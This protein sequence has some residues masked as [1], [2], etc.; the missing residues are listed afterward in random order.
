MQ[1]AAN[2]NL[3]HNEAST[4]KLTQIGSNTS[5][6]TKNDWNN[7][8]QHQEFRFE[9]FL[10]TD[11]DS[12]S[13]EVGSCPSP[14]IGF[15]GPEIDSSPEIGFSVSGIDS[16]SSP[17]I[18]L[19]APEIDS[20]SSLEIGFS[21]S[22]IDSSSSPETDSERSESSTTDTEFDGETSDLNVESES[23]MMDPT[24]CDLLDVSESKTDSDAEEN[25]DSDESNQEI[26][27]QNM[28][29]KILSLI[30]E[31]VISYNNVHYDDD[32]LEEGNVIFEPDYDDIDE[33]ER[34]EF[35]VSMA[36]TRISFVSNKT[37]LSY[38]ATVVKSGVFKIVF[39]MI[40]KKNPN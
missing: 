38:E 21:G 30:S 18:G 35:D 4:S 3:T 8:T 36:G 29:E 26:F 19:N 39:K 23:E 32:I 20:P 27:R 2:N 34:F 16:S 1:T 40:F 12:A 28:T 15:S 5:N 9:G 33:N 6:W 22:G 31:P 7:L 37:Y 24:H 11:E 13:I 17:D 14:D 10:S 25:F